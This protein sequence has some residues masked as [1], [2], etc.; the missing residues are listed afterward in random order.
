MLNDIYED[1]HGDTSEHSGNIT[2]GDQIGNMTIAKIS[3][4]I[5][6]DG[7]RTGKHQ[8]EEEINQ[9]TF[10]EGFKNGIQQGN[11]C[12]EL[13][14]DIMVTM[15]KSKHIPK[16]LFNTIQDKLLDQMNQQIPIKLIVS[17]MR[18]AIELHVELIPCIERFENKILGYR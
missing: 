9:I 16:K 10:D 13:L 1:I 7:Y 15:T 17:E 2:G 18:I 4:A 11:I 3:S 5:Y 14:A 12:G 6:N 8:G